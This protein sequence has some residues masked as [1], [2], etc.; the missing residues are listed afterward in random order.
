M[1]IR[2]KLYLNIPS[3]L[4]GT[5][6]LFSSMCKVLIFVLKNIMLDSNVFVISYFTGYCDIFSKPR[7]NLE[8]RNLKIR[9]KF[10]PHMLYAGKCRQLVH[11]Q[12]NL[13]SG[14]RTET[15][16]C[17]KAPRY[18]FWE[19][20]SEYIV[21]VSYQPCITL[22]VMTGFCTQDLLSLLVGAE[23]HSKLPGWWPV[24][25]LTQWLNHP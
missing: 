8:F 23:A 10:L 15:Y 6:L 20:V 18:L 17:L 16:I 5:E 9:W 14:T 19:R 2:V 21:H 3:L 7:V 11:T 12:N 1:M 24:E 25:T 13:E 22:H 4:L